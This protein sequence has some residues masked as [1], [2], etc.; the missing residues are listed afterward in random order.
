[1]IP[2]TES[3]MPIV[4]PRTVVIHDDRY[5]AIAIHMTH[6]T[7]V[8]GYQFFHRLYRL[9]G[10]VTNKINFNGQTIQNQILASLLPVGHTKGVSKNKWFFFLNKNIHNDLLIDRRSKLSCVMSIRFNLLSRLERRLREYLVPHT[11]P[12]VPH[13]FASVH[14]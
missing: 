2:I 12:L 3:G 8:A 7:N 14:Y 10:T 1:M 6:M 9:S 4:S 13:G 5:E 11:L